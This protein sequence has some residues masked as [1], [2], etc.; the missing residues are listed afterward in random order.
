MAGDSGSDSG[1]AVGGG[2]GVA[3]DSGS[4]SAIEEEDESGDSESGSPKEIK[5]PRGPTPS[6]KMWDAASGAWVK[7][8]TMARDEDE[9]EDS[10]EEEEGNAGYA[11]KY[12]YQSS[13]KTVLPW[14]MCIALVGVVCTTES[15]TACVGCPNCAR[16]TCSLCV[17][18]GKTMPTQQKAPSL[19]KSQVLLSI[20]IHGIRR[21]CVLLRKVMIPLHYSLYCR[22]T[23]SHHSTLQHSIPHPTQHRYG[24]GGANHGQTFPRKNHRDHEERVSNSTAHAVCA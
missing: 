14:L 17:E 1:Q 13:W 4:D 10:E 22:R 8:T 12:T 6:G 5:R 19:S 15:G 23:F 3:G 7:I 11:K 18:R 2:G 16:L 9:S 21:T 24:R 20:R